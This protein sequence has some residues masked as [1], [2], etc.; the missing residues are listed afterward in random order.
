MS[1]TIGNKTQLTR[2]IL[3]NIPESVISEDG[4]F[5]EMVVDQDLTDEE[6][7]ERDYICV[8]LIKDN[9][10][11]KMIHGFPGDTPLGTVYKNGEFITNLVGGMDSDDDLDEFETWYTNL[12]KSG[13]EYDKTFFMG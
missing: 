4:E 1:I 10:L 11:Y 5:L 8:D 6:L 3:N 7:I 12:T 2:D 9:E 13:T